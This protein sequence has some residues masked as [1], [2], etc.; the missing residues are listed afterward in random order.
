MRSQSSI[1]FLTTYS[2]LFIILGVAISVLIFIAGTPAATIP[3][4]CSAFAGPTCNF[5]YIYTNASAGYT[6]VTFSL[7]NSQP[8]PVNVTNTMVSYK[9]N[10]FAGACTPNLVYPGEGSTCTAEI[11]G[12]ISLTTLVQGFYLLNA[13]FCNSGVYNLSNSRCTFESVK[14]TGSFQA[15]PSRARDIIFSVAALQG[16]SYLQL[17]PFNAIKNS[18]TQPVNFT[19]V[20]NGGWTTN[21][22]SSGALAYAFAGNGI[23]TS[24]TYLG[25]TTLPYPS[26]LSKLSSPNVACSAPY[27]SMLSIAS[28]TLYISSAVSASLA[29][30]TGGGMNVYFRVAQPGTVWQNFPGTSAWGAAYTTQNQ[31]PTTFTPNSI[32]LNANTLYNVEALWTNPCGSNGGQVLKLSGLPG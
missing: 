13:Q 22:S 3:S 16:P 20:Q 23:M 11:G 9:N 5:V 25:Y 1:E 28:T 4:Q 19:L 7:T 32:S 27:N 26:S 8:V 10:N 14:Y 31:L 29:V 12:A 21:I 18:P 2:F 6:T 24:N 30:E 17:L 15:V